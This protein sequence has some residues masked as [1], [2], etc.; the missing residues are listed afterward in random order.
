MG[1]E[2]PPVTAGRGGDRTLEKPEPSNGLVWEVQ[3]F[4]SA[5]VGMGS[6]PAINGGFPVTA[7][8]AWGFSVANVEC[9]RLP[10]INGGSLSSNGTLAP[11]RLPISRFDPINVGFGRLPAILVDSDPLNMAFPS[12]LLRSRTRLHH[13]TNVLPSIRTGTL[14]A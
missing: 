8:I 11:P 13:T 1:D 2:D 12:G 4:L 3:G 14:E 9:P 5:I 7:L 10:A 6:L